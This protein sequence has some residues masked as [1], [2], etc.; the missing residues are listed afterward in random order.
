MNL[1][2]KTSNATEIREMTDVSELLVT[3]MCDVGC[4]T[5]RD[6]VIF[7]R[8][9]SVCIISVRR[10]P[11]LKNILTIYLKQALFSLIRQ[12]NL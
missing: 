1:H 4:P 11:K 3:E 8:A 9:D 12:P 10:R 7:W 2:R 5:E 6:E